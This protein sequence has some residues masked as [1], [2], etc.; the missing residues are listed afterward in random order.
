MPKLWPLLSAK[1]LMRRWA[2]SESELLSLIFHGLPAFRFYKGEYLEV[3]AE[4]ID[5]DDPAKFAGLV[6]RSMDVSALESDPEFIHVMHGDVPLDGED[7]REL[8]QLREEKKKWDASILAAVQAGI[9]CSE[10]HD[11][12]TRGELTDFI[13][14]I[15]KLPDCR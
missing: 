2:C 15:E 1:R 8:G 4:E 5:G 6:F 7:A 14:K 9:H 13:I 10:I 12:I 11:E 3:K